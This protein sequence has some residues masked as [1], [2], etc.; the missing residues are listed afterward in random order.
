MSD[1][2]N[3]SSSCPTPGAHRT[4]GECVRAKHIAT[5]WLGGTGPSYGAQRQWDKDNATYRQVVKDGGSISTAM[6]KGVDAAYKE[7]GKG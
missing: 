2:S 4:F 7:I 3:C 5:Q 1:T 6:H